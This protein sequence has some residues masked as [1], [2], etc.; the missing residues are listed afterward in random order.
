MDRLKR[1]AT[2]ASTVRSYCVIMCDMMERG[3]CYSEPRIQ[4]L[5]INQRVKHG[6]KREAFGCKLSTPE[7]STQHKLRECLGNDSSEV[8]LYDD[9]PRVCQSSWRRSRGRAPRARPSPF[10]AG[11]LLFRCWYGRSSRRR[12]SESAPPRHSP[13]SGAGNERHF[14]N[15]VIG[16][17]LT[18][19]RILQVVSTVYW[20]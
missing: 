3:I 19:H 12:C 13:A 15:R 7:L 17:Y 1:N 11:S 8:Q 14:S 16:M 2:P 6:A 20:V 4:R 18:R 10:S 5:T 9:L